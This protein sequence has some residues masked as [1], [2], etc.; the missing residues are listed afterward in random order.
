M[1]CSKGDLPLVQVRTL[2]VTNK[3]KEF[4]QIIL[5]YHLKVGDEIPLYFIGHVTDVGL[6]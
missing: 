3:Q 2:L 1:F 4:P 5:S 6:S